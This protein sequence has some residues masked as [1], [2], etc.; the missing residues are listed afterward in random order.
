MK[1]KLLLLLLLANFSIY[2][3]TNL[4]P[5]GDFETWSS[6]S[7]PDNWYRYFSGFI[8]QST[9]AQKGSSSTNM[10][11]SSGT[12]NYINSE[13]FP[14]TA[15]KTY[16]ITMYHKLVSGT[17]SALDFSLYH[18]PGTFKAEII[19]KTDAVFSSSEWRKI[20]FEYTPTVSENIEIDIWTTGT[21]NSE[22]LVDNI[23]VVDVADVPSPYTLIP[24]VNFENRLIALGIDSGTADGKVLTANIIK[25]KIL[26]LATTIVYDLTGLED[27]YNL[28][29]LYCSGASDP[30]GGVTGKL[31]KLNVT[32]NTKLTTLYCSGNQLTDLDVSQNLALK[33]LYCP[34]NKL[35]TIDITKNLSLEKFFIAGNSLTTIDVSKNLSLIQLNV[36]SN[37]ISN[38]DLTA[39]KALETLTINQNKITDLDVSQNLKLTYLS[40]SGNNLAKSPDLTKNKALESFTA[41]NSLLTT[42]DLSQN[43]ALRSLDLRQN[44]FE[45]LDVSNNPGLTTLYLQENLLTSLNLTNNTS[46]LSNQISFT[47]NPK[48]TCIQV[49]DVAAAN[50]NW[51][52]K[53][54]PT[55]SFSS[56][57]CIAPGS[58]TLIPDINFEKKLIA[59][60]ID[61][62]A[63]DGKVLTSKISTIT[64][65]DLYYSNISD[66]TGI[67]DFKSLTSL[68]CMSNNIT[69][70]DI[71]QNLQLLSLEAGFNNLTTLNTSKNLTLLYL[72]L[73]YNQITNLDLSQ[74]VNLRLLSVDSNKLTNIDT[75][76]N[77]NLS[78]LWCASNLLTSLDLSKNRSL[79]SLKCP[80]NKLLTTINLKNGNNRSMQITYNAINFTENPLLT[81]I[82][83]DNALYSNEKWGSFKDVS[84]SYSTVDCSQV[85]AI[86]DPAFEDKLIALNIDKDGKNGTV[87][88]S[89]IENIASLDVASSTIKN[90]TGIKGFTSL[91]SL[92]CSGNLLSLLDVSQNK[93]LTLLNCTNNSLESLNLKNGN[94]INFDV[95]SNFKNN[96]NLNCIQVDDD[97]YA[98]TNWST[99]KDTAANYNV[100]CTR[101]TLIPDSNFEDKLIALEI[102]KDGKNGKV[103][104]ASV[105]KVISLDISNS[106]ISDISGIEDFI[107]LTSLNCNY[108]TISNINIKNNEALLGLDL[109]ENKL[110]S[111]DVTKNKKLLSLTFSENQVS[112]IDLSQNKELHFLTCDRNLLN[113]LDI[114]SN[115]QLRSL[116]CGQDNL[117]TLNISNQ[118]NLE[119]LSCN[120]TTI[121]KLDVSS[122]KKLENLYFSSN[123]L[124]SL[125]LS[126]NPLLKIISLSWNK[127]TSLD[128]SHNPL[129]ELVFLEFNPLT[130]LNVQNGNNKNFV[131]PSKSGKNAA[132]AIY[133]SFLGNKTLSCIQVD[134]ADYSNANWAN[135]K[136][137]SATYS[138]TC[139]TLGIDTNNFE[140][141][142]IYPNPTKGDLNIQNASLEKATLYNSLGQLVKSFTLNSSDLNNTIDLSGLPK[143]VYYIYLI[144]KDAASAKKIIVE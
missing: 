50:T 6:S 43:K 115:T 128:L 122:N 69:S 68:S 95:N 57:P 79:T 125:D 127:L 35:T 129:L 88:N 84:A 7:Q 12:F 27:F 144:N 28:E 70:L 139:K 33:L 77:K 23:S 41:A 87:L 98:N 32:K 131:L 67:Q 34:Y 119:T 110:T 11:I 106:N 44:K 40:V 13:F 75:S 120:F 109:F 73:A 136:E 94:N 100:D 143:G 76:N 72:T 60:G 42:I 91:N 138:N 26:D 46:L 117:T 132:T 51:S 39:N 92:N 107:A 124:A 37:Q 24:D 20:E 142:T 15:N 78:A 97:A 19:K 114:S 102:D 140:K 25:V 2:A 22:I 29:T 31:T 108:N 104:T 52:T 118:P 53:K 62:G 85:T 89:S 135:I 9:T 65:I 36:S 90:L 4:V 14:V 1:I 54:D 16:R 56:T 8:S 82:L 3:Q 17:F 93:A 47:S 64:E 86:P 105:N 66:L 71:S 130:S 123:Q 101:Y 99:F 74:N 134:D 133:T 121:S 45:T 58:Y 141:V 21:L 113:D 61:S 83:V 5:N 116:S 59:L 30:N 55:T 10:K 81:C 103:A 126:N 96:P 38:I 112:T 49:S 63:P 18:K 80:E 137:K 48:L 111:L